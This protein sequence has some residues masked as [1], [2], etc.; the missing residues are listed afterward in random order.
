MARGAF[1]RVANMMSSAHFRWSR[2][3]TLNI[4][5]AE[6]RQAF[7]VKRADGNVRLRIGGRP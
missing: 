6:Q 5:K 4:A 1:F 3:G 2:P 7:H